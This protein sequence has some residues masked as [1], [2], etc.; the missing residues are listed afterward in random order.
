L[1][2]NDIDLDI[3]MYFKDESLILKDILKKYTI[4]FY[5]IEDYPFDLPG[6][7]NII[8]EVNP[9]QELDTS[10]WD[11][12]AESKIDNKEETDYTDKGK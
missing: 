9:F 2:R 11:P 4:D 1:K 12:K 10:G 3:R 5:G 6:A 7:E 8:A